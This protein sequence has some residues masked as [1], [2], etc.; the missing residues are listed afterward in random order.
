MTDQLLEYCFKWFSVKSVLHLKEKPCKY[1]ST[2]QHSLHYTTMVYL[3]HQ[4]THN[5]HQ[6]THNCHQVTHLISKRLI[7]I[8][9]YKIRLKYLST[10]Q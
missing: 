5:C 3:L 9:I 2:E 4:L 1:T 7:E 10:P 6:L 8:N